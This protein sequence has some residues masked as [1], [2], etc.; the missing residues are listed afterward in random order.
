M[1][2]IIDYGMGNLRSVEKAF[3]RFSKKVR[4]SSAPEDIFSSDKIVLP[5]VGAFG[6]AMEELRKRNL[7]DTILKTIKNNVPF[8]GICLGL[9]LLFS[10]SEE[11]GTPFGLDVFKGKVR[12][13]KD[14]GDLKIPHMGWNSLDI[15]EK[16]NK[17]LKNVKSGSYM[18]FVHSYY[19]EPEDKSIILCSTDYGKPFTSGIHKDNVYAFQFHPEKSQKIGLNIIKN[20]VEL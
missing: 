18:Y 16:D 19:V 11:G 9:Q 12:L 1:I 5:G 4:I 13:F 17:I 7:V 14:I 8:L 20:F 15:A 3:E 6:K 2:T 10:E